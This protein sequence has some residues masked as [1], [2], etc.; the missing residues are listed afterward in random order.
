MPK[1][2]LFPS[3]GKTKAGRYGF[4]KDAKEEIGGGTQP[5]P[6]RGLE[7][8]GHLREINQRL[9]QGLS[10]HALNFAGEGKKHFEG[11]VKSSSSSLFFR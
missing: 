7:A 8:G 9:A 5:A 1:L 4:G 2:K 10:C 3:H 11:S 6:L